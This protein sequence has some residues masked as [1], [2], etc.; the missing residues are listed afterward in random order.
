MMNGKG[1]PP[2][3]RKWRSEEGVLEKFAEVDV[4]GVLVC[5]RMT[6]GARTA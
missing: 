2:K 4:R 5:P 1:C 6:V 3:P